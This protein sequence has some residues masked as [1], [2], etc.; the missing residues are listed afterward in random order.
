MQL[1]GSVTFEMDSFLQNRERVRGS[2]AK[3]K[4]PL[5]P[6]SVWYSFKEK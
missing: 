3:A 2:L 1:D 4:D 5:M 6:K